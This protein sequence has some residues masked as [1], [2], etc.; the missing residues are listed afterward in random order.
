MGSVHGLFK[1]EKKEEEEKQHFPSKSFHF[2]R[3]LVI[4]TVMG[5]DPFESLPLKIGIQNSLDPNKRVHVACDQKKEFPSETSQLQNL[6][7]MKL[8]LMTT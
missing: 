7:Y 3:D 2:W 4:S 5:L 1:R 8:S 6:R